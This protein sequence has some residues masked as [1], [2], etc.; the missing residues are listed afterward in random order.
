MHKTHAATKSNVAAGIEAFVPRGEST[1]H[2]RSIVSC[3]A[4]YEA[5]KA[6]GSSLAYHPESTFV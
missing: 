2:K 3:R 5:R 1:A 4:A 6:Y